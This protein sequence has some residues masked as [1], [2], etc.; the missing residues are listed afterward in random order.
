MSLELINTVVALTTTAVIA[1]TAV[2]ALAQL[3]HLRAGNQIAGFLTLREMLDDDAHQRATA[4]LEREANIA[5]DE[6]YRAYA[7]AVFANVPTPGNERFRD[8]RAAVL[9]LAN[10]FEVMGTLVRNGI[11]DRRLFMEQY[12]STIVSQWQRLEAYI[13]AAREVQHDD[14]IWEDFEYLTVLSRDFIARY[15]SAYPKDMPRLL[16]SYQKGQAQPD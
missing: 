6:D 14:G 12:C 15:P 16:P 11:V 10:A 7:R 4:L 1:A 5:A 9:M 3:R 8:V 2:A 13:I